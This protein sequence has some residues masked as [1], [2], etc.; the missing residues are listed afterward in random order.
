MSGHVH[1]KL[2]A[3]YAQDAMETERPW[4]RWE[5]LAPGRDWKP[6]EGLLSW[7]TAIK[8]RRKTITIHI[9][10]FEVPEPC[11]EPLEAGTHYY[12]PDLVGSVDDLN[13]G[14]WFGSEWGDDD[15]D[16]TRL[17]AGIVH[18]TKEAA[19]MHAKALLHSPR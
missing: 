9:N 5:L 3:L 16:H 7:N 17:K 14:G 11:R 10:G 8:Y 19:D 15:I 18:L 12:M 4:E 13:G 1:A 2:M 6:C